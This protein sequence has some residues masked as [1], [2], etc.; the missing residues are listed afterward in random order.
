LADNQKQQVSLNQG[1]SEL[2]ASINKSAL[3]IKAQNAQIKKLG[4]NITQK[5]QYIGQLNARVETIK[6]SI[7]QIVRQTSALDNTSIIEVL[8]SSENL[9]AF[10]KNSDNY[11]E[12]NG[13]LHE[14][15]LELGGVRKTTEQ[16]KKELENKKAQVEKL[17]YEQEKTKK[18]LENL[19]NEKQ[20]ILNVTKGQEAEYK[21]DIAAKERAKNQLNRL[22]NLVGVD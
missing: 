21:K 10:L 8:L 15:V 6:D 20:R 22:F 11:S 19:K 7:G 1:I 14:L 13:K 9:S 4:S 16:E 18:L 2:S 17:K 12:I 5:Q 3:E